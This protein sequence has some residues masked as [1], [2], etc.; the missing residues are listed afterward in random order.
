MEASSDGHYECIDLLLTAGADVNASNSDGSN[1]LHITDHTFYIECIKRLLSAGIHINKFS[2]S[3]GK[4]AL[5][6]IMDDGVVDKETI[7]LLYAAGETLDGTEE[8]K[9]PEMLKFEDEKLELKHICREAIR[10]HLLKLDL[11]SNLFSRIP[12][13]RLPSALTKY[14]LYNSSLE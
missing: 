7:M 14:L 13:L 3:Q 9:I 11:H 2:R 12:E 10:K 6:I 4:N 8:E 1:A 5:G